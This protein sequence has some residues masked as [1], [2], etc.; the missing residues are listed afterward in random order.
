[1]HTQLLGEDMAGGP[2]HGTGHQPSSVRKAQGAGACCEGSVLTYGLTRANE[3][4]AA[5]HA[6]EAARGGHVRPAHAGAALLQQRRGSVHDTAGGGVSTVGRA[7]GPAAGRAHLLLLVCAMVALTLRMRIT[8][9]L[10]RAGVLRAAQRPRSAPA[11]RPHTRERARCAR[12]PLQVSEAITLALRMLCARCCTSLGVL[13]TTQ[14]V[15]G[16]A[17]WGGRMDQ[18]HCERT[19][20]RSARRSRWRCASASRAA[21]RAPWSCVQHSGRGQH[22]RRGRWWGQHGGLGAW[23]NG[24]ASTHRAVSPSCTAGRP[25]ARAG[26]GEAPRLRC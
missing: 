9:C 15:V 24:M 12:L 13:C 17:Q 25:L 26:W 23:T 21:S 5:A 1:M 8:R 11:P 16:S 22:R 10:T 14:R 4:G 2:K 20:S 3:A 18:R 19:I 7:H 6:P